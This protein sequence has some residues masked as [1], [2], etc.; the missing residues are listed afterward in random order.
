[1]VKHHSVDP[2]AGQPED[3]AS[4]WYRG[5][6]GH[7]GGPFEFNV[8]GIESADWEQNPSTA[9]HNV[10]SA[11][12]DNYEV[13]GDDHTTPTITAYCVGCHEEIH[14]HSMDINDP[15]SAWIRHPSDRLLPETGEYSTYNPVTSYD[16]TV[17]VGWTDIT[18]PTRATAS[19]ICL[20]C[21]RAHGSEYPDMLRWDYAGA[22]IAGGGPLSEG[23]FVCH[24][25]KDD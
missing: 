9:N 13:F 25:T 23:C 6:G 5:L 3:A 15:L 11:R 10:Y 21:H 16:P 24:S 1:R 17:P 18:A 8:P 12:S 22:M 19:V 14:Y 20:S 7:Y 2:V 4:G